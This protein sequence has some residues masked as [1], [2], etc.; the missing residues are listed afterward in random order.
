MASKRPRKGQKLSY[1]G[2][3]VIEGLKEVIA[4]RAYL[5]VIDRFPD[6]VEKALMGAA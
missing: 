4:H 1:V 2:R 3:G 5:T 6:T